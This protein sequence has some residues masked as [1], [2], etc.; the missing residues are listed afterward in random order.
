ME[1]G[2]SFVV[3][4]TPSCGAHLF[5][6]LGAGLLKVRS[7]RSDNSWWD[8]QGYPSACGETALQSTGP[9]FVS[10]IQLTFPPSFLNTGAIPRN[11][12]RFGFQ[13]DNECCVSLVSSSR[14]VLML[15]CDV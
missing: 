6:Q 8:D 14:C 9:L 12:P 4:L 7:L 2:R 1:Q 15:G 11:V 13:C 5:L 10:T 3:A